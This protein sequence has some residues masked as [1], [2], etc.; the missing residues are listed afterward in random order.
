[1][2]A[3][4]RIM[5]VCDVKKCLVLTF[6]HFTIFFKNKITNDGK[7]AN[8]VRKFEL[9]KCIMPTFM[10]TCTE[11][12]YSKVWCRF[13]HVYMYNCSGHTRVCVIF[14]QYKCCPQVQF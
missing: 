2:W 9:K 7:N 5:S 6:T 1:M 8:Y 11:V 12:P 13:P 3:Q 10:L 4:V 14:P